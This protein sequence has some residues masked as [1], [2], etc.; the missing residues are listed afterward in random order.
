VLYSFFPLPLPL[1]EAFAWPWWVSALIAACIAL[2]S[3][4][5]FYRGVRDAGEETMI[6]RKEHTMYGGIYQ[7]IR[8]P[9]AVGELPFWW[10]IAF[11]LHS[12]FLVLYS[13]AWI[14]VFVLM[15]LAE[16]R[17]L[18]IRY[19]KSYEEY[20]QRTGFLIPRR[21][22][23][24]CYPPSTLRLT[25]TGIRAGCNGGY[26]DTASPEL[27]QPTKAGIMVRAC[28]GRHASSSWEI[29]GDYGLEAD[30]AQPDCY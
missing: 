1:P 13:F 20:R 18:V 29:N 21:L 22:F 3:G 15:C 16:E 7:R 12:P 23:S 27:V 6:V 10:V 4:Y 19:G 2:P 24:P 14:P 25:S 17:D 9:Q 28:V 26:R 11:L 5:I 30:V 8:H